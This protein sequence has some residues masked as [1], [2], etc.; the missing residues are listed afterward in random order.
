MLEVRVSRQ[1]PSFPNLF[2]FG[3]FRQNLLIDQ[4]VANG[5]YR[6]HNRMLYSVSNFKITKYYVKQFDENVCE[7]EVI[8]L[9]FL[10]LNRNVLET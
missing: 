1:L 8:T 7:T 3:V 10:K 6:R 5:F 9:Y 2:K 4:N